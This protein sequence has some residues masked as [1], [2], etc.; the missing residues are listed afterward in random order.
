M[1]EP[2]PDDLNVFTCGS[3]DEERDAEYHFDLLAFEHLKGL[4]EVHKQVPG[5]LLRSPRNPERR[6]VK[7]DR[8]L[9]PTQ[10][11]VENGWRCGPIGVEI[12]RSGMPL[13]PVILQCMDYRESIFDVF[14]SEKPIALDT[15]FIFPAMAIKYTAASIAVG[16]RVGFCEP[17]ENRLRLVLG[18]Q[19]AL[20]CRSGEITHRVPVTDSMGRKRGS[21]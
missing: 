9:V 13:G 14:G 11:A 10:K 5:M 17:D 8:V 18:D 20:S 1:A 4:F 15:V 3:F 2:T 12:K 6:S 16:F 7:I 19:T 21:R